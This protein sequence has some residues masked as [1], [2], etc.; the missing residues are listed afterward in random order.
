MSRSGGDGRSLELIGDE[1]M[2]RKSILRATVAA[3]AL[4]VVS[5]TGSHGAVAE[6]VHITHGNSYVDVDS[7]GHV[8]CSVEGWTVCADDD[9]D[10]DDD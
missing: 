3:V 6:G 7:D 9:D 5:L 1:N 10:D 4:T 2:T 8:T